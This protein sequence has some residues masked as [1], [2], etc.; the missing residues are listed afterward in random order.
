MADL[1]QLMSLKGAQAAFAMNDRGELQ[2][3]VVAEGSAASW[4]AGRRNA[5]AIETSSTFILR[6]P[7]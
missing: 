1:N 2:D 6:P 4:L 7:D 3:H 5:K